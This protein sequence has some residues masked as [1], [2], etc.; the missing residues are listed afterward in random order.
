MNYQ[1]LFTQA[2]KQQAL[3]DQLTQR[4]LQ[5]RAPQQTGRIVPKMGI[6]EGLSQVAEAMIARRTGKKA[7]KTLSS[8][9]QVRAQA[10]ADAVAGM[11]QQSENPY[12]TGQN[13]IEAGVNPGVV[14]Q[15]MGNQQPAKPELT[16]DIK[17]YNHAVS[18][19]YE[20]SL[21]DFIKEMKQAGAST[22]TVNNKMEGPVPQGYM[23]V[24]DPQGNLLNYE[25]IPGS[26]QALA[27][28]KEAIAAQKGDENQVRSS[29]IVLDE[30]NRSF[31]LM[32]DDG[33]LPEAGFFGDMIKGFGSTDAHALQNTLKTIKANI[34][35]DRLQQMREA[36]PTGG[37]LGNVSDTEIS[38]LQAVAG[39]LEQSQRPEDLKYNLARYYNMLADIVHGK[40][41]GPERRALP[42]LNKKPGATVNGVSWSIEE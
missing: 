25:V 39:S 17:E 40:G 14:G 38:T 27:L 42:E 9:E 18:Q 30:I 12:A 1:Q 36:S 2:Q 4:A 16:D 32:E 7:D 19:G 10:I 8:A 24:R 20:G 21:T 5:S 26:P 22:T 11:G 33:I 6:G 23:A 34:G 41:N 28:E 13:A 29:D 15:Y 37:A 3:A 31:D 35:F